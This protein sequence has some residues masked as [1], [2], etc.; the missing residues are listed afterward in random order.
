MR[1]RNIAGLFVVAIVVALPA[2]AQQTDGRNA[3]AAPA[4]MSVA[5][6][7]ALNLA[8][9]AVG[10][11]R[12]EEVA[13]AIAPLESSHLSPYERSRL[14]QIRFNL[15]F[16]KGEQDEGRAHLEAAIAAGGLSTQEREQARYQIAQSYLAEQRWQDG[17]AR[18]EQ[19]FASVQNPNS[20]AYYLLGVAYYQMGDHDRALVPAQ[21]AVDLSDTP[22]ESW[23]SM[24]VAL[25]LER[26]EYRDAARLLQQLIVLVPAKKTYWLQL[27]ACYGQLEDYR[28]AL[29]VMQLAFDAGLLTEETEIRRYADLLLFNDLPYRGARVLEDAIDR[30]AVGLVDAAV[31]EKLADCWI[32]AREFERAVAPLQ[33]AAELSVSG[34]PLVRLAEVHAERDDWPAAEGA[35]RRAL[36]KGALSDAAHAKVLL[37]SITPQRA[38]VA[39]E[40][41]RVSE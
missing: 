8:I 2:T 39:V 12:Y 13:A 40:R 7:K 27:S 25:R 28:G 29:A 4:E 14:E 31:Y 16:A 1:Y 38:G 6:A 34:D 18:L 17:A 35:L 21:R 5:T 26:H 33:R 11:Q 19:W 30:Q 36:A 32:A 22:Q 24:L 9:E 23:T 41:Q 20:A 10:K 15:A 3:R 37:A